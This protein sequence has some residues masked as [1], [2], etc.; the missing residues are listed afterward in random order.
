M[1]GWTKAGR[2]VELTPWQE[3]QVR[4]LLGR[5]AV[6][7]PERP[8]GCGWSTVLA[9]VAYMDGIRWF[10]TGEELYAEVKSGMRAWHP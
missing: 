6:T 4:A 2:E 9:T 7:L 5:E 8:A 3:T 1:K 10:I